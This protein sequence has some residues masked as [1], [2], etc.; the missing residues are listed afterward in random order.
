MLSSETQRFPLKNI[1]EVINV[2]AQMTHDLGYLHFADP[3]SMDYQNG[4]LNGLPTWTTKMDYP[5]LPTFKKKE[6]ISKAWLFIDR[7]PQVLRAISAI[8]FYKCCWSAVLQAH[9]FVACAWGGTPRN[10]WYPISDQNIPFS[11]PVFRPGP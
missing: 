10:F 4:L 11:T 3:Q 8:L 2:S 5:K 1:G 9:S 6:K 7:F